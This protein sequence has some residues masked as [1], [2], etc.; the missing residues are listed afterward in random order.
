M[1]VEKTPGEYVRDLKSKRES[2][3]LSLDDVFQKTRIRSAYLEAIENGDFDVLPDPVYTRNFIKTYA[4]F[5]GVSEDA[6]LKHYEDHIQSREAENRILRKQH[7][8]KASSVNTA[9]K[10]KIYGWLLAAVIA[11]FAVWLLLRQTH[12]VGDSAL[13]SNQ[14]LEPQ[15]QQSVASGSPNTNQIPPQ[16]QAEIKTNE[17]V[18]GRPESNLPMQ[19][20]EKSDSG[21]GKKQLTVDNAAKDLVIVALEETWL[22]VQTEGEENPTEILLKPGEQLRKNGNAFRLDIGNAGGVSI[23]FKGKNIDNIGKKGEVVHMRLPQ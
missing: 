9:F 11:A 20:K 22:K 4:R 1:F 14:P 5:L 8:E 10:N 17:D 2:L 6:L 19:D 21:A 13:S 23:T 12:P 3:G 15:T 7:S 18:S 16:T